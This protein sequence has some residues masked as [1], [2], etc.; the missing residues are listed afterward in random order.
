MDYT[1]LDLQTDT[2]HNCTIDIV[3]DN[4]TSV[5]ITVDNYFYITTYP[6]NNTNCYYGGRCL[7]ISTR[8]IDKSVCGNRSDSEII[9]TINNQSTDGQTVISIGF[10]YK[11]WGDG[12][13][14]PYFRL[15]YTG[16]K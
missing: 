2:W 11:E 14:V 6:A 12:S 16:R 10:D 1:K 8:T 4:P 7:W 15:R 13:E 9:R 3:V 5:S